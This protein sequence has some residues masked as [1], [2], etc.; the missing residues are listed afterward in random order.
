MI[1]NKTV[2]KKYFLDISRYYNVLQPRHDLVAFT[3]GVLDLQDYLFH[4]F[5]PSYH[6]TYYHPYPFDDKVLSLFRVYKRHHLIPPF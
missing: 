5:S 2:C 1:G 4:E 6:V 3:N